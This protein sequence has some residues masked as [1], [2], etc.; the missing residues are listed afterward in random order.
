M[1]LLA[2]TD[3]NNHQLPDRSLFYMQ[4]IVFELKGIDVY[5][6]KENICTHDLIEAM[7]NE[8]ED[9]MPVRKSN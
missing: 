5:T 3:N 6:C 9:P 2:A 1:K 7:R 8:E 4:S